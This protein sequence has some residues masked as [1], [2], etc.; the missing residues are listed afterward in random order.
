MPYIPSNSISNIPKRCRYSNLPKH[1]YRNINCSFIQN[2][3]KVKNPNVCPSAKNNKCYSHSNELKKKKNYCLTPQRWCSQL[4]YTTLHGENRSANWFL[5]AGERLEESTM[6]SA[7]WQE[8]FRISIFVGGT[9]VYTPI[10]IDGCDQFMVR[11]IR[12][13]ITSSGEKGKLNEVGASRNFFLDNGNAL[14]LDWDELYH[15]IK[16]SDLTKTVHW[17]SV[18]STESKLYFN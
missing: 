13:V 10:Q 17:K 1:I 11:E 12:K 5:L 9:C 2:S 6:V 14:N 7:G 15:H 16:L 3:P 8:M 4:Y 18:H